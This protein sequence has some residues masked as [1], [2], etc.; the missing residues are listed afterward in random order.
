MSM[1]E[2]MVVCGGGGWSVEELLKIEVESAGIKWSPDSVQ[3]GINSGTSFGA[4][5]V[6]NEHATAP[7]D[8]EGIV[9]FG[10]TYLVY[11]GS[12]ENN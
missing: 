6:P 7:F 12:E 1:V 4:V 9:Y 8:K 10:A 2:L 3:D 11:S 5:K